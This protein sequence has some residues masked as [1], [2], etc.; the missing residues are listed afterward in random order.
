M[1]ERRCQQGVDWLTHKN[2]RISTAQEFHTHVIDVLR[3]RAVAQMQIVAGRKQKS[4]AGVRLS[5]EAALSPSRLSSS[6]DSQSS[7]PAKN[8]L[9]N[10]SSKTS[11]PIGKESTL[12]CGS[13]PGLVN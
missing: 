2:P 9:V 10:L 3:I 1:S 6:T 12:I 5:T 11:F 8:V 4:K 13:T 7:G